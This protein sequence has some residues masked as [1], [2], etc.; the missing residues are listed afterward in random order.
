M[1]LFPSW[2]GESYPLSSQ[3]PTL[4][5]NFSV[6]WPNDVWRAPWNGLPNP[7]HWPNSISSIPCCLL[8]YLT[9]KKGPY[10]DML[11]CLPWVDSP[12]SMSILLSQSHTQRVPFRGLKTQLVPEFPCLIFVC[13]VEVDTNKK[14]LLKGIHHWWPTLHRNLKKVAFHQTATHKKKKNPHIFFPNCKPPILKPYPRVHPEFKLKIIS[15]ICPSHLGHAWSICV[16]VL[17]IDTL[18]KLVR[19]CFLFETHQ[20]KV[21][22]VQLGS[23]PLSNKK[24][25]F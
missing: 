1:R 17:N 14:S 8:I 21:L 18:G 22:K 19:L 4:Q 16:Y 23:T 11:K 20:K 5:H 7:I 10:E 12:S 15:I 2:Q 25:M 6:L 24:C 9:Q 13:F 3:W